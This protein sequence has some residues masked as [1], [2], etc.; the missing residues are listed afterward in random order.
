MKIDENWCD[1]PPEQGHNYWWTYYCP[2]L[3]KWVAPAQFT[4]LS[5]FVSG[6]G[7]APWFRSIH[8]IPDHVPPPLPKEKP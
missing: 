5:T 8:P 4:F 7:N 3:R 1:D 6:A 2:V